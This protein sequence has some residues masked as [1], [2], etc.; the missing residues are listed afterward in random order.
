MN[1]K[2]NKYYF[3]INSEAN[4]IFFEC[5]NG[6]H[7]MLSNSICS[8]IP[9]L[10]P[11]AREYPNK[12]NS[13]KW[14]K[15]GKKWVSFLWRGFFCEDNNCVPSYEH[16]SHLYIG[17]QSSMD[18]LYFMN[19]GAVIHFFLKKKKGKKEIEEIRFYTN[20]QAD[21]NGIRIQNYL[22]NSSYQNIPIYWEGTGGLYPLE[23]G[24]IVTPSFCSSGKLCDMK[25]YELNHIE[26]SR[27][28][29]FVQ[30][31]FSLAKYLE[32]SRA[33]RELPSYFCELADSSFD[34]KSWE[35]AM[36][37]ESIPLEHNCVHPFYKND[38]CIAELVIVNL[39]WG[40][41]Y[42]PY[43][44]SYVLLL[45][46]SPSVESCVIQLFDLVLEKFPSIR[47]IENKEI[48]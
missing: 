36:T 41:S 31:V 18:T 12:W 6:L 17:F 27:S 4:Y 25:A 1:R 35:M 8:Y 47:L 45:R 43:Q 10:P 13:Q 32:E 22:H 21:R 37:A 14:N 23:G 19:N 44:D 30:G 3:D 11:N 24:F 39:I 9:E 38:I 29:D 48:I 28:I 42:Y 16:Y 34:Y 5:K 15:C 7:Y 33:F 46:Y 20:Q 2:I 40:T 26:N